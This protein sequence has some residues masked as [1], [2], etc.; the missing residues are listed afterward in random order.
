MNR[1]NNECMKMTLRNL[2]LLFVGDLDR[3][4]QLQKAAKLHGLKISMETEMRPAPNKGTDD[5]PDVVILDGFPQSKTALSAYYQ[6]Q[7]DNE[8]LFIALN[9][10]PN[11]MKFLHVNA[12]SSI[13]MIDRDPEPEELVNAIYDL[14][15]SNRKL[16]SKH[17]GAIGVGSKSYGRKLINLCDVEGNACC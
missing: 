11:A 14:V 12:L 5:M 4:K 16:S 6:L 7:P 2:L 1:K 15:E 9:D 3:G 10:S 8:I 17:P 13:K